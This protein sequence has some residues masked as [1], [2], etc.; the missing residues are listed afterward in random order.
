[1]TGRRLQISK[2][3]RNKY[4]SRGVISAFWSYEGS[5]HPQL[6]QTEG[7]FAFYN[8]IRIIKKF[9]ALPGQI[10]LNDFQGIYCRKNCLTRH[11]EAVLYQILLR[12]YVSAKISFKKCL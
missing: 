7:K 3:T 1:M 2:L 4:A 11:L 10:S 9:Y 6:I 5:V 12:G 8:N